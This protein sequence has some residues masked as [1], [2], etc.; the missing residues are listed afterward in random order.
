MKK[1]KSQTLEQ[2][3]NLDDEEVFH[4]F[5]VGVPQTDD[6]IKGWIIELVNK[7]RRSKTSG[8]SSIGCGNCQV[9]VYYDAEKDI[10]DIIVSKNFKEAHI[11]FKE[12]GI[13]DFGRIPI[14]ID[15]KSDTWH[16]NHEMVW[17]D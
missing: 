1:G 8:M 4:D 14:K 5:T 16:L 17:D 7:A 3:L 10:A 9:A 2:F 12:D 15:L 13:I 11:Y 6:T